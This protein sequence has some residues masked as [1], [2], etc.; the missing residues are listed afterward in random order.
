MYIYIKNKL[1]NQIIITIDISFS[2][3]TIEELRD[4]DEVSLKTTMDL[5]KEKTKMD[6]EKEKT[7]LDI[8]KTT[9]DLEKEKTTYATMTLDCIL[10]MKTVEVKECSESRS[11][12]SVNNNDE[13]E[14][15]ADEKDRSSES[16][17]DF[18]DFYLDENTYSGS[19]EAVGELESDIAQLATKSDQSERGAAYRLHGDGGSELSDEVS[20][21]Y[22]DF[23]CNS[24]IDRDS[25]RQYPIIDEGGGDETKRSS[26]RQSNHDGRT[27]PVVKTLPQETTPPEAT[28]RTSSASSY[29]SAEHDKLERRRLAGGDYPERGE[30]LV[31]PD[32][33]DDPVLA[34]SGSAGENRPL[35]TKTTGRISSVGSGQSDREPGERVASRSAVERDV[36]DAE[37]VVEEENRAQN[38]PHTTEDMASFSKS[39]QSSECDFDDFYIDSDSG[40]S[41]A[42]VQLED[43]AGGSATEER[44]TGDGGGAVVKKAFLSN[45]IS[46]CESDG[47][48]YSRTGEHRNLEDGAEI[49]KLDTQCS[50]VF[51]FII[52]YL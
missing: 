34:I 10:K 32:V 1:L 31:S 26:L 35:D 43:D 8:E 16:T 27:D 42:P 51:K 21:D 36:V 39:D 2:T 44:V 40:G 49:G 48:L 33:A 13:S 9:L 23:Y 45:T 20:S 17:Y 14:A 6:L 7:I 15:D 52:S 18:D 47:K 41:D 46:R 50:K 5:E 25:V 37:V 11:R 12:E 30:P 29:Y 4:E 28:S 22:S 19:E 3:N 38:D 24:D